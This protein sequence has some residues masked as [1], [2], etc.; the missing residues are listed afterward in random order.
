MCIFF[1]KLNGKFIDKKV[2][3]YFKIFFWDL[4][5]FKRSKEKIVGLEFRVR[6]GSAIKKKSVY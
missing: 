1:G 3:K 5:R 2:R 4:K 6:G